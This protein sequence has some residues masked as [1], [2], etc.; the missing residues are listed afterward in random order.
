MLANGLNNYVNYFSFPYPKYHWLKNTLEKVWQYLRRYLLF[1][2]SCSL[3]STKNQYVLWQ[4]AFLAFHFE[5]R[6]HNAAMTSCF[7]IV[8][9]CQN[10]LLGLKVKSLNYYVVE[11][12]APSNDFGSTWLNAELFILSLKFWSAISFCTAQHR[13]TSTFTTNQ[14]AAW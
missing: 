13:I 3:W 2:I 8:F 1:N 7:Q 6:F 5:H 4:P 12:K 11:I 9:K 14:T 10:Y